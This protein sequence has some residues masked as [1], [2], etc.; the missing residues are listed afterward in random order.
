MK[1]SSSRPRRTAAQSRG[2]SASLR[3]LAARR[4]SLL[5][6]GALASL[7]AQA[8][9]ASSLSVEALTFNT[10]RTVTFHALTGWTPRK[11]QAR[12]HGLSLT[13]INTLSIGAFTSQ[14]LPPPPAGATYAYNNSTG[15]FSNNFTPLIPA[16]GTSFGDTLAFGG[17]TYTAT[18]DLTSSKPLNITTLTFS[19]SGAVILARGT[20]SSSNLITMG[21]TTPTI[22]LNN[23]GTVTNALDL[24]LAANT[25][26][27]G[28]G[29]ATFSGAI[30][31][32]G[33]GL[34]KSGIYALSTTTS[35]GAG[36]ANTAV[37]GTLTL[38]GADTYTGATTVSVGTVQVAGGAGS[39]SGTSGLTVNGNAVFIDGD[40]TAATNNGINN[41]VNS[42]APLT[43]GGTGGG[44]TFNLALGTT[45]DSQTLASL[46]INPGGNVIGTQNTGIGSLTFTG[47][48]GGAGY[49][50]NTGGVVN[51]V[52]ATGFTPS[53]TNAPTAAGG[54]SVSGTGT[55]AILTGAF[56]NNNDFVSAAAGT[57]AA[58]TYTTNGAS[59][60][61]AGANIN[62]TGGN[63]T[64][65]GST[66]LSV[67]SLRFPDTTQRT[68]ALGT[69]S[70]LTVASGGI[71]APATVT[72][73]NVNHT[74]SGGSITSGVGD[75]IINASSGTSG[76]VTRS[77][78]TNGNSRVASYALTIG[79]NIVDGAGAAS[80][81]ALTV[82]G[83][84]T[85]GGGGQVLLSG[86]NTYSGGTFL[87]GGFVAV[88][89]DSGLGA[90]T[91]TVTAVSGVNSI[92]PT[93]SF[94]FNASRN[95]V[96]NSGALLSIGDRL[97]INTTIAGTLSGG[98]IFETGFVSNAQRV[99]LTGNNSG[100]TGQYQVNGFLQANEGAGLSSNAN[101]I[102]A[103]RGGFGSGVL[104]TSGTFTRSLG[105]G[106]GQVQWS[107]PNVGYSDGGFAATGGAL[108]VN[109]GGLGTPATLTQNV[110]GF[111]SGNSILTLQD[112]ASTAALT[113]SNPINNN[114]STLTVNQGAASASA[115]TSAT[116]NG[117]LSGTGGLTKNG[118][119][120]L[121]LAGAN[122][123]T[124]AT[125]VTNGILSV[126]SLNHIAAGTLGGSNSP[127][128][129]SS[130]GAPTTAANGT[131]AIGTANTGGTLLYTGSG[132]TTDRILSLAGTTGGATLD[133]SGTGLL[134]F[135]SNL[136]APGTAAM[137][138]R[139]TL[140][141]QGST[142]GT[143]EI[144]GSIVDST[145]GTSGQ[146]TTSLTKA[147][148]DTWTLSGANTYSGT[149]L[150]SGGTLQIGNG[151]ASGTLGSG[152][153]T[154]NATLTFNR[155]DAVTVSNVIG[156]TG[157]VTQAGSG[158]TTLS[159]A[160]SYSGL[161]T[162]SA[163]ILQLGA[164]GG[165]TNT[166]LG[167]NAAG[168]TVSATGAALD[169]N[170]FTLGTAEA[171]TLN[172][173]GVSSGGALTNS[174][175]TTAT[176]SGLLTLGSASSIVASSG[177]ILLSNAGTITGAGFGLT[178]D[179]TATGSSLASILGTGAGTLTKAG[180]G[181]WTLSGANTYTGATAV[182]A[183][184]L[185]A[186]STQAFGVNSAVTLANVSGAALDI[187]GFNNS[188]GS[189][190]GGGATGGNVTLGAATL[191][192]GGDNTSPAAYAGILSGTGSLIKTGTG[193]LTFTGANGYAGNTTV[194]GGALTIGNGT[195]GIIN[196]STTGNLNVGN[197]AGNA[198][199]NINSGSLT[200]TANLIYVGN[201]NGA[202][203][204]VNL[205]S[206]TFTSPLAD[207]DNNGGVF[208]EAGGSYGALNV[209]G[210]TLNIARIYAGFAG[211]GVVNISGGTVNINSGAG[212]YGFIINRGAAP[213]DV[214]TVSGGT[215]NNSAAPQGLYVGFQGSGGAQ[216]NVTGG[217]VNNSARTLNY[218]AGWT[219]TGVVNLDAG[220][221]QTNSI[222]ANSGTD[223][224]NF[225][226]GTLK[227]GT[228]GSTAFVPSNV[229]A[230]YVNGTFGAFTGGAV[231]DTN[232]QSETVVANLLAPTGSGVAGLAV[233][234]GTGYVGSPV[235]SIS[236]TGTGATAIANIDASGNLTG[237][238][239]TNPGV[240]YTGT[241]TFTLIGGGGTGATPGTVTTA[242]N[243]S[244]G[245]TKQG[246][247]I[248]TLSGANTYTGATAVNAGTLKA[249]STQAFGVNS[250][251]TLAN[252]SGAALD[253]TGFNN[254]IGSLTGGGATGGNVTLGAATLTVGGDN[255]SPAAYA[256]S[257]SGT[258]S[259]IK[260][261][262]G[263]L[264]LSG[265][266]TYTGATSVSGGTLK[267]A[268]GGS[269][270]GTGTGTAVSISS[271]AALNAAATNTIG[272][273]AATT[274]VTNSGTLSLASGAINQLSISTAAATTSLTL[275]GPD[276]LTFDVT[277]NT[278]DSILLGGKASV[279]GT[280]SITL[281]DLAGS[282]TGNSGNAIP[283]IT[284]NNG[285]VGL[286]SQ[287]TLLTTSLDGYNLSLQDSGSVLSLL[288]TPQLVTN[289]ASAY[290]TGSQ[291][292]VWNTNNSGATNFVTTANG[293]TAAAPGANTAV[294][295]T[296]N[297]ASNFS[298]T[299]L[300]ANTAINSLN[301]TGTGTPAT[302]AIGIGGANTLTLNAGSGVGINDTAGTGALTI[303]A[304]VALGANQ[305]WTNGSGSLMSVSGGVSG[306]GNLALNSNGSGGITV[307]GASVNNSGTLTNSG[308]GSGPT[309]ISAVIGANVSGVTQNSAT[310]SLVL[311]GANTYSGGTTVS[312]GTLQ[313]GSSTAFGASGGTLTVSGGT[314][315]VH[316]NSLSVGTLS[317]T[318][319]TVVNNGS[320]SATLSVGTGNATGG[321]YGGVIAD[322][323]SGT[324]TLSVA[325]VGS[326]TETLT[327][328]NT[329]SGTTIVS[330]GTL[331]L[332]NSA[333]NH[334][335]LTG[336]GVTV[337]GSGTFVTAGNAS[338]GVLSLGAANQL[339]GATTRATTTGQGG[340]DVT[341]TGGTLELNGTNQGS[342]SNSG[343]PRMG[344]NAGV[345]ES[346]FGAG[347][348]TVS[349]GN[350]YL[351]FGAGNTGAVFTFS[352][353]DLSSTGTLYIE[354][355]NDGNFTGTYA[356][357]S[358]GGIDQLFFGNG[359][360]SVQELM[361]V[362]FVNP[363]G[364]G[365]GVKTGIWE[366]KLLSTGEVVAPE[367][368]A[369]ASL[370]VGTLGLAGLAMKARRRKAVDA[371]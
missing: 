309:S 332:N 144:S 247:G 128:A 63:T 230:A 134:K 242:A 277:G 302:G 125:S 275:T 33:F 8:A 363:I 217:T 113:W 53:F 149:T 279:T 359:Q 145:L 109:L 96:V 344:G 329:Y 324:G 129:S 76:A 28:T 192:V 305:S 89:A 300:G 78:T 176:Y 304:P 326:G 370:L 135:T 140:T 127:A 306:S 95:F 83:G 69:G 97:L 158:T 189:L 360:Y 172:G 292:S 121:N 34:T 341:L 146:L 252:V 211:T 111:L 365:G 133:Q 234:G 208:G 239:V 122:T 187:T 26:V 258:G 193:T 287:F 66:T 6:V 132:E 184:T 209:S 154:D 299:T 24:A 284:A 5:A 27:T 240:G 353:Y 166:P 13:G 186:G 60:L 294:Y 55:N 138:N 107:S 218:G 335:T 37:G 3:R 182:N 21:G 342:T 315:D 238:T 185:K 318:G 235:V 19:N 51:V 333:A 54:S 180:S 29:N 323:T 245:L 79:S 347:L 17:A 246:T 268:T 248:L 220:T 147:G 368:S 120:L 160:N 175:A 44:G 10:A 131:I 338:N 237:I 77:G 289:G 116:M 273:A 136:T 339:Q 225:N 210:G 355:Y 280:T 195:S 244:G 163:G 249:G 58:P 52:S 354:N 320:G 312:A 112:S 75:L 47:T 31:G 261:G 32:S 171:L 49:V 232:G 202:A 251:V 366:A 4:L 224:L 80:P 228:A 36:L 130:L 2:M 301:T 73:D 106:A 358:G 104:E 351:D 296:A 161:T 72:T 227:G 270:G 201:A 88:N 334:T 196:S 307:S 226:G 84:S 23:A 173:T 168:T 194:S 343:S 229:S 159:G 18:D 190:T 278:A 46:T 12:H 264:T 48:A 199:L 7:G 100:F 281:T 283:L 207:G 310:S 174:S 314:A 346:S 260:T 214:V 256:G 295:F 276:S 143:G 203:S 330:A 178:L 11:S 74:I 321:S 223:Y 322:H 269:I 35:L 221:L 179:G 212:G 71:L 115:T 313:A 25:T 327:G 119:G 103:G 152:G 213:T 272:N 14:A 267:L 219:G 311:S 362:Y 9:S 169:L 137:D 165:A 59:T 191:T 16:G 254:S 82:T 285:A 253:I 198:V 22:T 38:S 319:G 350:S 30:T 181:T 86:V 139:K 65:P 56:L 263:T 162:I 204:A 156:G 206:G 259:L 170:G 64:L 93:A 110:G 148:T 101:L 39:L 177:N 337:S 328:A 336:S 68:L 274:G 243:T 142:T 43:L 231:F 153:V 164:A 317:G 356:G 98:G 151:G 105:T 216:L 188:I 81:M 15:S 150:I 345:T 371:A 290:W 124:G 298:S 255:T 114:G 91:G 215:L 20:G 94:T 167:T 308:T 126:S 67:N 50:R 108:T 222:V 352:G 286:L 62:V 99:I 141:L 291:G 157:A 85:A 293:T 340:T 316:G 40:S 266:N 236:G 41:R 288:E 349:G 233:T 367:P 200:D 241:P 271:G 92:A 369:W 282:I 45:A 325:K 123:Y 348:L 197:V 117:L 257:L 331:A 364:A 118:A 205:A 183:G 303:S 361:H 1:A 70:T 155:S 57:L 262:T 357:A 297:A 42:A 87:D 90:T 250:A 265:A 102:L 61:T